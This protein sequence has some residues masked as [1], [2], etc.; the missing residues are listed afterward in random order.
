MEKDKAVTD[1]KRISTYG[2]SHTLS[3]EEDR[4][5]ALRDGRSTYLGRLWER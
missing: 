5:A 1:M 3:I 2:T 4:S